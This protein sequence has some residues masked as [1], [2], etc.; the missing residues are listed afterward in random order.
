MEPQET[1]PARRRRPF[2][3]YAIIA[4]LILQLLGN[5]LDVLRLRLGL[6][7]LVLPNLD[8]LFYITILNGATIAIVAV[9][10]VG[11]FLFKRWAW[12]AAMIVI[13]ISLIYTIVL[14]LG[15]GQP[16][17][18]MFIAVVSVFYL[19]QRNVQAAFEGRTV[20]P[21]V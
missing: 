7:P 3:V 9:I 2:G 12:I 18:S 14:Y 19:N 17:A 20:R 1:M 15:G 21:E 4:L 16:F 10:C 6:M 13:G 11:L 8:N 5:S